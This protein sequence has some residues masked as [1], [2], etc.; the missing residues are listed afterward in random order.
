MAPPKSL[1]F[2]PFPVLSTHIILFIFSFQLINSCHK[3]IAIKSFLE[4]ELHFET[5]KK[6]VF[7][8][9]RTDESKQGARRRQNNWGMGQR[10]M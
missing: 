2:T 8:S 6:G 9:K 5:A 10:P 4:K 1:K 3:I 7:A